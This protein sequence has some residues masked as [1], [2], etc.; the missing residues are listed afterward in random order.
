MGVARGKAALWSAER[1]HLG[2]KPDRTAPEVGRFLIQTLAEWLVVCR[3][4]A[5]LGVHCRKLV[6]T[7]GLLPTSSARSCP[8]PKAMFPRL[9]ILAVQVKEGHISG[10]QGVFLLEAGTPSTLICCW[11]SRAFAGRPR[12]PSPCHGCHWGTRSSDSLPASQSL[13]YPRKEPDPPL[14]G[15]AQFPLSLLSPLKCEPDME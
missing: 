5:Q 9:G 14:P 10:S 3:L 13:R 8:Y 7:L 4:Q 2:P 12:H 15:R 11:T 6:T 1:C